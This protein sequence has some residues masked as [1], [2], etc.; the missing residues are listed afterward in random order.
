MKKDISKKTVAVLLIIAIAFS[1]TGTWIVM[2][3]GSAIIDLRD[4]QEEGRNTARISLTIED[5][6]NAPPELPQEGESRI[7]LV[8]APRK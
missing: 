1:I 2:S 8:I 3:K 5:K 4:L 7:S 6:N